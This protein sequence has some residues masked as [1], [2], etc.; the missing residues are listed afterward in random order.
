M[1][2]ENEIREEAYYDTLDAG[3]PKCRQ[4]GCTERER[5]LIWCSNGSCDHSICLKCVTPIL[6]AL[7]CCSEACA[8]EYAEFFQLR[9]EELRG[10]VRQVSRTSSA[11]IQKLEQQ[12]RE[13]TRKPPARVVSP[14]EKEAA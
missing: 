13:A 1:T 6:L 3:K 11:R 7:E 10:Q 9:V 4:C 2:T 8:I 5:E 14:F 12:L